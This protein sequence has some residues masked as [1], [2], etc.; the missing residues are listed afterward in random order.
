MKVCVYGGVPV[1]ARNSPVAVILEP[2]DFKN[3]A[4]MIPGAS[5]YAAFPDG[6]DVSAMERWVS[7]L[8]RWGAAP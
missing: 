5:V 7:D 1:D 2:S 8:K 3:I 6:T 4:N